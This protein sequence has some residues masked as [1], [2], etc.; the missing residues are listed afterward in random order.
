MGRKIRH[1]KL[2]KVSHPYDLEAAGKKWS[3]YIQPDGALEIYVGGARNIISAIGYGSIM[4][5]RAESLPV[6]D[7]EGE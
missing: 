2:S 3:I 5:L 4:V 6:T 1:T 7:R